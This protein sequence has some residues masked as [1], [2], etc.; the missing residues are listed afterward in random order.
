MQQ[1]FFNCYASKRNFK[2][3]NLISQ[4]EILQETQGSLIL[5]SKACLGMHWINSPYVY[6]VNTLSHWDI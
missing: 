6:S 5:T 4:K 1:L 2:S 3:K